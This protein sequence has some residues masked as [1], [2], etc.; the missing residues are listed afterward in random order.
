MN[1]PVFI[2]DY[3]KILLAHGSGGSLTNELIE[4][5][6]L[7]IFN[8]SELNKRHDGAVLNIGGS[9]L[10]F[11]TDSYVVSPPFFPGGDIGSLAVHGTVNDL[12]VCGAK[13]LFISVGFIIEEGLPLDTLENIV[14]SLKMAAGSAGVQIVTGDTKVV[15]NGKG[16]K[17]FINTS[18]IG[19][20]ECNINITP[21]SCRVGDIIIINGEIASHGIAVL[22]AREGFEFESDIQSDSAPLNS[23]VNEILVSSNN[24]H[25][26][27]DPTRGGVAGV[28]NEIASITGLGVLI[29]EG[30]IPISEPVKGI[31]EI[32]GFDPLYV[33]NEGKI[34]VFV[35]PE[36]S[37]KVLYVMKNHPLGKDSS[38]IG[39]M[40]PINPGKVIIKTLAGSTR[41]LDMLTG[42][43]LPRIC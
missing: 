3:K 23:L 4:N 18:G 10:A 20:I 2:N 35:S 11:T 31:C 40:T 16:D 8:N 43:Q 39:K 32:L 36:D 22:S 26:M 28:L 17:I 37:E 7:K 15:E 5:L 41:T 29:D 14:N 42:E 1:C 33:A 13:P 30:K 19:V 27:R 24:I 12:S 25:M 21:S 9:R 6:F 34:L 38:I